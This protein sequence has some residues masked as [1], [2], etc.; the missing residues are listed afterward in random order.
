MVPQRGGLSLRQ[1]GYT[2]LRK[3]GEIFVAHPNKF[4]VGPGAES[5]LILPG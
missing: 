4:I 1:L 5:D 2:G 3:T